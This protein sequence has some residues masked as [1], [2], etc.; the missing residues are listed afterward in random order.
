VDGFGIYGVLCVEAMWKYSRKFTTLIDLD[1]ILVL[2]GVLYYEGV[3]TDWWSMGDKLY[4]ICKTGATH[5]P[6]RIF[7]IC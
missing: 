1:Q 4:I 2:V 5:L 3:V 7:W 6:Y